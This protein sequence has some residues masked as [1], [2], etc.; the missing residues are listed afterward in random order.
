MIIFANC[1]LIDGNSAEPLEGM[2]VLVESN[3]IREVSDTEIKVSEARIIDLKGKTLGLLGAGKLGGQLG[4]Y[5]KA[6]GMILI[7]WSQILTDAR[8]AEV[9]A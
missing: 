1:R 6:F 3:V 8:A 9:G 2:H 7:A 5:A 4:Q